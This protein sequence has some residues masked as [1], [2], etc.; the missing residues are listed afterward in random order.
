MSSACRPEW[1]ATARSTE[2]AVANS[3]ESEMYR[4]ISA[5]R[6]NAV[7]MAQSGVSLNLLWVCKRKVCPAGGVATD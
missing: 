5:P 7:V 3:K 4:M 6:L 1:G 2:C